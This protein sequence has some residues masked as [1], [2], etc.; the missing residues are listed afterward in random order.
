MPARNAPSIHHLMNVTFILHH[1]QASFSIMYTVDGQDRS[2]DLVT[3]NKADFLLW[4]DGLS[5]IVEVA[6]SSR[7]GRAPQMDS[8]SF[9]MPVSAAYVSYVKYWAS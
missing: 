9:D 6:K 7:D 3:Q 4:T 1:L 8:L 5:K 2:L